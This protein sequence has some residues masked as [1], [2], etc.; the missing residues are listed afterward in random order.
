MLWLASCVVVCLLVLQRLGAYSVPADA[1]A[2][3]NPDDKAKVFEVLEAEDL[4]AERFRTDN[5]RWYCIRV[6]R[7]IP[8]PERLYARV[9]S[10]F[11]TYR[12]ESWTSGSGRKRLPLINKVVPTSSRD[13]ILD[14]LHIVMLYGLC[15]LVVPDLI[16]LSRSLS[17]ARVQAGEEAVGHVLGH[18]A[19]GCVSDPPGIQLCVSKLCAL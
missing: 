14:E 10:V 13:F 17:V 5:F 1:R 6:R 18:I 4:D 11:D 2:Q 19:K 8:P 3:E 9:K 15:L 7:R 12:G 16:V